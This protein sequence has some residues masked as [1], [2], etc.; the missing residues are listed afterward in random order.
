[1]TPPRKPA[2]LLAAAL[3]CFWVSPAHSAGGGGGGG[4]GATP[5]ATSPQYDPAVEFQNG[6]RAY[7]A[8]DYRAAVTAFRR[9]VEAAPRYAAGQYYLGASYIGQG[10]FRRARRPLEAA[11]RADP[12]L[13]EA[14]R[15]L[16]IAYLRTEEAGKAAEQR[17]IL[18][19]RQTTCAG[20]C[21]DAA[22]LAAALAAIDASMAGSP[23]AALGP[24]RTTETLASVDAAYVSA[25]SLINEQRYEPAIA[26]L[27]SALWSIGPHP[28]LLTY[29]GFAN[30]KL[31]RYEVARNWYEM[32]LA[33]APEHRG[34]LEYYGE[35]KLELGDVAG[36]RA[37][38]A[39]LDSLCGFGCQQADEL[40][41][42]IREH[43]QS[44]S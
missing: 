6:L 19:E 40:R 5:G 25:V 34:A 10:D 38:L 17:A 28:D 27:E 39:R 12:T 11:V 33:I 24:G 8:Q 20:T 43:P 7:S 14:H 1:M 29:L 41:S 13:I 23:P 2:L 32:A 26:E 9:V 15:D 42:W 44:G 16:A 18:A 4:G 36:A 3:A 31:H 22:K 37:H 21:P 30:R 35:L